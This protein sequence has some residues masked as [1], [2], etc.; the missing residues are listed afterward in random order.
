MCH[1]LSLY[2]QLAEIVL[3]LPRFQG[4]RSAHSGVKYFDTA[5]ITLHRIF[6]DLR[7]VND[8]HL[9][10]IFVFRRKPLAGTSTHLKSLLHPKRHY[11]HSAL[12]IGNNGK[13]FQP[14]GVIFG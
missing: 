10:V 8:L 4:I 13:R 14:I 6:I 1:D 12:C 5:P 11:G 7:G 2:R 9:G 3:C